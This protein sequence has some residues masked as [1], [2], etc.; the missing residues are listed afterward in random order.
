M[1]CSDRV[2]YADFNGKKMKSLAYLESTRRKRG[3]QE[4]KGLCFG[5]VEFAEFK[6]QTCRQD[7][8]PATKAGHVLESEGGTGDGRLVKLKP[9]KCVRTGRQFTWKRGWRLKPSN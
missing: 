4:E 8:C 6:G 1:P 5:H 2:N 7:P 9:H 3:F